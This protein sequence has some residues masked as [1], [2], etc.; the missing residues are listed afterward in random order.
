MEAAAGEEESF[1]IRIPDELVYHMLR[2]IVPQKNYYSRQSLS[3]SYYRSEST[4]QRA[5][6]GSRGVKTVVIPTKQNDEVVRDRKAVAN[7]C[8][9]SR[10]WIG[11][12]VELLPISFVVVHL[13]PRSAEKGWHVVAG[14]ALSNPGW[15]RK[16]RRAIERGPA[17]DVRQ[18]LNQSLLTAAPNGN[19]DL[20]RMLLR[21]GKYH[22][23]GSVYNT[24]FHTACRYG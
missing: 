21:D 4:N 16:I 3:P 24:S 14:I 6:R 2:L 12:I 10:T 20:S 11:Y 22:Y 9:V 7:A 18:L 15:R 23:W 5:Q 1:P 17:L 19:R 13:L 8:L